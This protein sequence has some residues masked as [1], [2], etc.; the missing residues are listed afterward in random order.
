MVGVK[1]MGQ[2]TTDFHLVPWLRMCGA[3]PLLLPRVFMA[4]TW[5]NSGTWTFH[6]IISVCCPQFIIF[7][8]KILILDKI[9]CIFLYCSS[10]SP[11]VIS[12][13]VICDT[14]YFV[15]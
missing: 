6:F 9:Y 5:L 1:Q 8:D 14:V 4:G 13:A 11:S 3:I 10:A 15:F 7:E 2:L 12:S